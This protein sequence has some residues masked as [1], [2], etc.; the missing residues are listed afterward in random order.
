[1][2]GNDIEGII[3]VGQEVGGKML[4]Y[5]SEG[6]GTRGLQSEHYTIMMSDIQ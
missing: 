5:G 3:D 1:M 6:N 4:G 2:R